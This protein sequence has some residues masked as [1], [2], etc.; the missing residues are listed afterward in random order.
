VSPGLHKVSLSGRAHEKTYTASQ[1]VNVEERVASEA[2][3][4]RPAVPT[5]FV[6]YGHG[7]VASLVP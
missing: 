4:P 2:K 3:R 6:P 5:V 7:V 1:I